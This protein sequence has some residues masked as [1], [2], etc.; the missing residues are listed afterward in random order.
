MSVVMVMRLQ[1]CALRALT[2]TLVFGAVN[3][4]APV[5]LAQQ[6]NSA[7]TT[8]R[9]PATTDNR[10]QAPAGQRLTPNP[11]IEPTR[12]VGVEDRAR[13][14]YTAQGI[15][16]GSFIILPT[17][18]NK[19]AYNDNIFATR[20]DK[21]DDFILDI[22][23]GVRAQSNWRNHALN[24]SVS[25]NIGLYNDNDAEDYEDL[26]IAVDGR[27]DVMKDSKAF[28]NVGFNHL[29]EERGSVDDANGRNPTTYNLY[30]AGLRYE[31]GLSKIRYSGGVGVTGYLYDN[32]ETSTGLIF[33][34]ERD[35]LEY[36][37]DL[38]GEYM[39]FEKYGAFVSV[40]GID[41]DYDRRTAA[42][43]LRSSKGYDAR[44]GVLIELT[45]LLAG[46]VY[47]GYVQRRYDDS[48]LTDIG[49]PIVG[50]NILWNLSGLTTV[51]M[52]VSRDV[53]ETTSIGVSGILNTGVEFIVNHELKRNILLRGE[54][55]YRESE[56][57]GTGRSDD[58][59]EAELG[60]QYLLNQNFSFEAS[61]KYT[62]RSSSL[63]LQSYEQTVASVTLVAKM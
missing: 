1:S 55:G 27:F 57:R 56:F 52:D 2:F 3:A 47:G 45:G 5:V 21:I 4:M 32:T 22:E 63:S 20:D 25:G 23:P 53:T 17:L 38:R 26:I 8:Q 62:D 46:E 36:T 40:E 28:M 51:E 18:R 14:S 9:A 30:N 7:Q 13:E 61:L 19:L 48:S 11:K 60:A 37:A 58:I 29:H 24:A 44:A 16:A 42:G 15:R 6:S 35:R 50:A 10:R 43:L 12:G 54:L 34:D 33:S 39:F 59:Y 49:V 41:V 31:H